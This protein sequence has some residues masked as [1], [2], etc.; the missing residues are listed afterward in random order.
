MPR[1]GDRAAPPPAT[2]EW[3]LRFAD[4][5]AAQGWEDLCAQAPGATRKA[6]EQL[7]GA[8]RDPSNHRRQH[9]LRGSL[10]SR[11]IQGRELEQWQYEVT[12]GARIWYCIDDDVAT[13]WITHAGVGHPTVTD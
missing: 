7:A 8:P 12:G 3:T 11:V 4:K 5:A 1:R 9:R 13:V 6:W 10:G 2:G